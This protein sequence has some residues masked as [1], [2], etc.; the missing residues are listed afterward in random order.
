MT[1]KQF[2][3]NHQI[4]AT[5]TFDKAEPQTNQFTGKPSD[6]PEHQFYRFNVVLDYGGDLLPVNYG[7]GSGILAQFYAVAKRPAYAPSLGMGTAPDLARRL[8]WLIHKNSRTIDE[9]EAVTSG[10]QWAKSHYVPEPA[11]VLMSMAMDA[12]GLDYCLTYEEWAD[13]YGMDPDS[14]AGERTWQHCREQ[15]AELRNWLGCERF[16]EL[17]ECTEEDES[18]ADA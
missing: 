16:A 3:L 12:Y 9:Q 10:L 13:E 2:A 1:F 11:D 7:V 8:P 6:R 18:E 5:A 15:T 4:A 17:L 14:R